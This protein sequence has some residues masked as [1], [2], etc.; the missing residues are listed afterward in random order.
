MCAA[1]PSPVFRAPAAAGSKRP[2]GRSGANVTTAHQA[3]LNF[4]GGTLSNNPNEPA[5]QPEPQPGQSPQQP[6]GP[7]NPYPAQF[8]GQGQPFPQQPFPPQYQGQPYP[9]QFHGQPFPP[10]YPQGQHLPPQ[11]LPPQPPPAQGN[12][13]NSGKRFGVSFW[14]VGGLLSAMVL[15]Q[16]SGGYPELILMCLGIAAILTGLYSL[17]WKRKSWAGLP[18]RNAAMAVAIAGAAS[19]VIGG[20]ASGASPDRWESRASAETVTSATLE[21]DAAARLK[22]REDALVKAEAESAA[23]LTAREAAVQARE[24]A[25]GGAEA[26]AAANVIKEGTWTIG[27][28]IEPG[29]YRT[30]KEL[31]TSCYWSI[32]VTGSNGSDIIENDN[33]KG[34]FPQVVLSEGQTFESSRCGTWSKQ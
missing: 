25:I 3:S 33:V 14:I 12:P 8:P 28:D 5:N 19:L 9:P 23:K 27:K 31:A 26:A 1:C 18:S 2:G 11:H 22:A 29:T 16:A 6:E 13:G 7:G 24:K 15:S 20:I 32:T 21:A 17:I 34:G 4:L 10:Q 30:T